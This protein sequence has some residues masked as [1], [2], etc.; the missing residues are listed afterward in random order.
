[1]EEDL[2]GGNPFWDIN[3]GEN[4]YLSRVPLSCPQVANVSFEPNID[5]FCVGIL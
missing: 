5:I 3:Q 2:T 1:M 4:I